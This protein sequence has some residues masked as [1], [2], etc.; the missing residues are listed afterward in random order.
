MVIV[1]M[2]D[3]GIK[4]PEQI[5]T[6]L[7]GLGN[8]SLKVDKKDRNAWIARTLKQTGYFLLPKKDKTIVFKYLMAITN[9][10]RQQTSRLIKEY[11]EKK[12]IGKKKYQRNCFSK[13]YT[14]EDILLLVHTDEYH[15]TLSGPAT[16]KLFERGLNVYNDPAY[17]RLACI[18]VSH[19]YN[20]RKTQT[21]LLKRHHFKKT[22]RNAVSLGERRKPQPNGEPGYIRI[23]TVHQGD[24][25]KHKGV[26]YINAIDEVTQYQVVCCV[27]KISERYLI[28][29]LEFIL[30]AFPF[31]IKGFHSDNGSEYINKNVARLLNKLHIEFTKSRSRRSNDN[32]LVESKNGSTIRKIL[33]YVHIPQKWAP[34]INEFNKKY[35]VHYLNYH[36]PCFFAEE[37]INKKGK[38]IK[39]YP[40]KNIMTPY[41]KLKSLPNAKN[42]LKDNISF[43][44]LDQEVMAMTDL[45]SAKI[46]NKQREI[47]FKKIFPSGVNKQ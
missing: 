45:E 22:K 38:I 33:G 43:K 37:K 25:D 42:Y 27:E 40:Y 4:S 46:V 10:S 1:K 23:D 36:R 16:K 31:K 19:I 26:Y 29:A 18:S 47:L 28:P 14:R 17:E 24:L 30:N 44:Q 9:L 20:L 11:R 41:E 2:N 34:T 21:Y 3:E 6:F 8:L 39:S 15:Q 32:A 13:H 7:E 5:K 12:W 35:W